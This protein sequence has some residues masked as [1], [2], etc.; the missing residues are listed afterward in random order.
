[1]FVGE[2]LPQNVIGTSQASFAPQ[3]KK[4]TAR[5]NA[6]GGECGR[7]AIE[8]RPGARVAGT[9]HSGNGPRGP[10]IGIYLFQMPRAVSGESAVRIGSSSIATSGPARKPGSRPRRRAVPISDGPRF[11]GRPRPLL[12]CDLSRAAAP[13]RAPSSLA[14]GAPRARWPTG[15]RTPRWPPA[16]RHVRSPSLDD[17]GLDPG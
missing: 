8:P 16:A 5:A 4:D 2:A 3:A 9:G 14:Q 12:G 17:R 11:H 13:G 15:K 10:P 1:M 7:G 6:R